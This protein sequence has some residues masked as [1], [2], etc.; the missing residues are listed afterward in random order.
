M[1]DSDE[2]RVDE[3]SL[4]QNLPPDIYGDETSFGERELFNLSHW[5]CMGFLLLLGLAAAA[6]VVQ[7]IISLLNPDDNLASPIFIWIIA[8]VLM[9][10]IIVALAW[11]RVTNRK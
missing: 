1:P 6:T 7:L 5:G 9:A 2:S 8:I 10:A 4:E 3:S 11:T